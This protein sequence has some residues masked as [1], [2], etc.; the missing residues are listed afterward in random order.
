M[1]YAYAG[2]RAL[3]MQKGR[4]TGALSRRSFIHDHEKR[5]G[6]R[7]HLD[8]RRQIDRL[9][10]LAEELVD[11]AQYVLRIKDRKPC[12]TGLTA[13]PG[14]EMDDRA[15]YIANEA[16]QAAARYGLQSQ[17]VEHLIRLY[18]TRYKDVLTLVEQKPELGARISKNAPDIA[19]EAA[20]AVEREM[21]VRLTDFFVRRT[22]LV[23]RDG[24]SETTVAL[25]AR[26]FAERLKWD[27]AQTER[28]VNAWA[29]NARACSPCRPIMRRHN[30][31]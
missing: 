6:V 14:G 3:P 13:L 23:A 1:Q 27:A 8:Y 4:T 7:D 9:W 16:P 2:V 21:A 18:G 19:A 26:I 17:Q 25:A 12:R 28:E 30:L 22:G 11:H 24:S 20:Y 10:H 31:A 29:K 15:Q 5:E